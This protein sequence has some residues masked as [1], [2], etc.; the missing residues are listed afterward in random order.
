MKRYLS[1]LVLLVAVSLVLTACPAPAPQIVEVE[2]QV[3]VEKVVI[4][5]VE[6][7]KEVPVEKVVKE[8]VEVVKEVL[9]EP[10]YVSLRTNW[11]FGGLHAPMFYGRD[12]GFFREQNIVVDIREGNGSGNVVRTIINKTD[13]F[14]LISAGV[15][16]LNV[17]QGAPIKL[18]LPMLGAFDWGYT[19]RP[20]SGVQGPK[21][22]E[23]KIIISSP[24]NAGLAYHPIFIE[25][26]GL[27]PTKMQD[28]T[29]V[30][31]GA[32]VST[33]LSGNGDC[34]LS[35]YPATVPLWEKEGVTPVLV[36]LESIG[37]W[38]PSVGYITHQDMIDQ[39]PDVVRR[40]AAALRKSQAECEKNVDACIDSLINANPFLDREAEKQALEIYF[41][42]FLG[43]NQKCVGE[44]V[45]E[46]WEALLQLM[47]LTPDTPLVTDTRP[48]EGFFDSQFLAPC[49]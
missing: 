16:M 31:A 35:G 45:K 23:G 2:K 30:D 5:T 46:N 47:K 1:V 24:G 6:V 42:V 28:L 36:P 21:D 27:D 15:P 12:Q 7:V 41:G 34:V 17:A 48:I 37:P 44:Y 40:M 22:L 18:V 32:M 43:P 19:C 25:R 29:L 26:A 9:V 4:Q 10:D 20:D 38:G 8:T 13:D 11:I 33:A 49:E 39:K 3:P 14:A